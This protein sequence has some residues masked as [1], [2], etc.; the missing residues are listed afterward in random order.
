MQLDKQVYEKDIE[1]DELYCFGRESTSSNHW[2]FTSYETGYK[3]DLKGVRMP[4]KDIK[5]DMKDI[6]I[7]FFLA[8]GIKY[9]KENAVL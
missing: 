4:I 9:S 5:G 8:V 6:G 3:S 1:F 7:Y 2:I